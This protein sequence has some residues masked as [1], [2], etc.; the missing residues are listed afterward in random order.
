MISNTSSCR[1][2]RLISVNTLAKV[3]AIF[4][5]KH[6]RV[7]ASVIPFSK[8]LIANRVGGGILKSLF[9]GM[10]GSILSK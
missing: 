3:L 6:S 1:Y 9:G 4:V 10:A 7:G 2:P 8:D 5:R